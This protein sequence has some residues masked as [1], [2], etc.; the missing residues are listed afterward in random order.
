MRHLAMVKIVGSIPT[1]RSTL[2]TL[3]KVASELD[4]VSEHVHAGM[5]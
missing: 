1:A 2:V 3:R 4:L 5:V